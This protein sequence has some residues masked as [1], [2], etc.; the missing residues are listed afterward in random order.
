MVL[1]NHK[2]SLK[3]VLYC[4]VKHTGKYGCSIVYD[5]LLHCLE[6]G[7]AVP[8]VEKY[9]LRQVAQRSSRKS[10]PLAHSAWAGQHSSIQHIVQTSPQMIFTCSQQ[11]KEFLGGRRFRSD[12]EVKDAVRECLN[13]PA[14]EVYDEGIKKLVTVHDNCLNFGGDCAEK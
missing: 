6:K 2:E 12:E 13:G 11:L 1:R 5:L 4:N 14:A 10:R 7:Q 8:A 9:N 3:N